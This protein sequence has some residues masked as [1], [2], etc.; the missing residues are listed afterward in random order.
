MLLLSACGASA[1]PAETSAL[2]APPIR[3]INP[4]TAAPATARPP[5]PASDQMPVIVTAAPATARPPANSDLAILRQG[6]GQDD[7]GVTVAFVVKNTSDQRSYERVPYQIAMYAADRRVVG[8]VAGTLMLL[9]PGTTVGM[10]DRALVDDAVIDL[11]VMIAAGPAVA[12]VRPPRP[13]FESRQ[14]HYD[15]Q[16]A[17]QVTGI[18]V[19]NL[20][21]DVQQIQVN[22]IA[23]TADDTIVGGGSRILPRLAASSETAVAVPIR[24]TALPARVELW[25]T[26]TQESFI[27]AQP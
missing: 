16:Q 21:R 10:V 8:T 22:A 5:T 20:V 13:I 18:L 9:L 2:L 25:A 24:T 15:D 27:T 12:S 17:P 11:D 14:S 26:F 4:V 23:Y 19:N 6:W 1:P 3:G 7:Q